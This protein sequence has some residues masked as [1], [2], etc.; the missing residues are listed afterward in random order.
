VTL[1]SIDL[2]K[3]QAFA[4]SLTNS[5]TSPAVIGLVGTL[6]AGKTTLV[7]AMAKNWGIDSSEVTSP[8]F[9]LLQTHQVPDSRSN[10]RR[11]HHLDAYRVADTDEW[12]ELGVDE[13]MEQ[14]GSVTIIEWADRVWESLPSD[15]IRIELRLSEQEDCREIILSGGSPSPEGTSRVIEKIVHTFRASAS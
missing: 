13:L 11:I 12:F 7:Q 6:G 10:V 4:E 5:V 1:S 8:T 3:L 9:T 14:T 15:T 2:S